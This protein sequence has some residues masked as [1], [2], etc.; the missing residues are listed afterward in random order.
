MPAVAALAKDSIE[1]LHGRL[2]PLRVLFPKDGQLLVMIA[3]G[4]M[5]FLALLLVSAARQR[6]SGDQID[7]GVIDLQLIFKDSNGDHLT[8]QPPR[9][10]V[11][12]IGVVDKAFAID[13][14]INDLSRVEANRW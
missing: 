6:M 4:T 2:A 12:I 13:F 11:S 9:S 7:G 5:A 14:A 10:A 8:D 3:W 1:V